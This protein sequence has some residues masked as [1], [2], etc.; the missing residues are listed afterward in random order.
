MA[1]PERAGSGAGG[2]SPPEGGGG[3][4]GG[5]G[6]G[7]G[8]GLKSVLTLWREKVFALLVQARVTEMQHRTLLQ[9]ALSKVSQQVE[10]G[11]CIPVFLV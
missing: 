8:E 11:V 10:L 9:E 4:G 5:G 1:G 6:R 7:G 3:G 2:I